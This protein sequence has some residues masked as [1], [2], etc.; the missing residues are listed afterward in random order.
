MKREGRAEQ[1]YIREVF[2]SIAPGYDRMNRLMS[3]GLDRYWRSVLIK[4]SGLSEGDTV[5]D[6]CTGTGKLAFLLSEKVGASGSVTGLD[7]SE[8]MLARARNKLKYKTGRSKNPAP[9]NFIRGNALRLPFVAE[10]FD[11]VTSAFALRNLA[12]LRQGLAEMTRVCKKGGRILCLDITRP[13]G[14]LFQY[15][16]RL[17]FN[18]LVPVLGRLADKGRRIQGQMPA[19]CWLPLSLEGFP[20]GPEMTT[21]LS[22]AGLREVYYLPLTRGM[23]TLY[24]GTK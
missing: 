17:Y 21:F 23:V 16:F 13:S 6:V 9:I 5:L 4:Q 10:N 7:F 12:D 19:Y 22:A 14:F 18:G 24:V 2:D 3:W 15:A 11:C 1:A 20:C 8:Q